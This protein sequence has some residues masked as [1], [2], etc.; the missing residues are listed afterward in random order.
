MS[1]LP[2]GYAELFDLVFER[3]AER[4]ARNPEESILSILEHEMLLRA[5][6]REGNQVQAA[7]LLGMSRQTLRNRLAEDDSTIPDQGI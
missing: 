5:M 2:S 7:K 3:L 4:H 1:A 6:K